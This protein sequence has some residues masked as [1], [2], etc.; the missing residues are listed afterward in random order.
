[1][2]SREDGINNPKSEVNENNHLCED[3]REPRLVSSGY[4]MEEGG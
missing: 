4:W 3:G 1:M 2:T